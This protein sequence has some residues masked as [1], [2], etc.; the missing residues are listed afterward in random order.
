MSV[1][2]DCLRCLNRSVCVM[3]HVDA[4]HN[5]VVRAAMHDQ[6]RLSP[7]DVLL[8]PGMSFER[9]YLVRYGHFKAVLLD[10]EGRS[11]TTGV[12][13]RGEVLGMEGLDQGQHQSEVTALQH[14]SVCVFRYDAW[15]DLL[16]R[17]PSLQHAWF[18][19]LSRSTRQAGQHMLLL[20]CLDG[21]ERVASFLVMLWQRVG[22]LHGESLDLMMTRQEIGNYL[23][24]TLESV[25]R[26]LS[27]FQR[28]GWIRLE[29]RRVTVLKPEA[30]QHQTLVKTSS[31]SPVR[32]AFQR[33][34][35]HGEQSLLNA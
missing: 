19:N 5:P 28:R 14:A 10:A 30:L 31:T 35:G 4:A 11:H 9:L 24:M 29:R 32:A 15:C 12:H 13:G 16:A 7:G 8:Y 26:H 3:G 33:S 27:T 22:D 23:G 1:N 17:I 21:Q 2:H 34:M 25:S 18:K 6:V 20:G